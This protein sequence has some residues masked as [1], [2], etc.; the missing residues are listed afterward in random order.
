MR[1]VSIVLAAFAAFIAFGRLCRWVHRNRDRNRAFRFAETVR[2]YLAN[3][4][5]N[6]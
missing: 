3:E 1:D 4:E 2:T 5:L 6:R